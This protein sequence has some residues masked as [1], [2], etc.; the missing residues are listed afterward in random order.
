MPE[1][2]SLWPRGNDES[3]PPSDFD[4]KTPPIKPLKSYLLDTSADYS[5]YQEGYWRQMEHYLLT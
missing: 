1:G 5:G 3:D 2:L 4:E